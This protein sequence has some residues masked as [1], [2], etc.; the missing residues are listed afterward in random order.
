MI[1]FKPEDKKP[2]FTEAQVAALQGFAETANRLAGEMADNYARA[3][4]DFGVPEALQSKQYVEM[5][6]NLELAANFWGF[7]FLQY[8]VPSLWARKEMEN[9]AQEG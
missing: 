7:Q 3:A 9:A 2:E 1:P 5:T 6:T 4:A 8:V